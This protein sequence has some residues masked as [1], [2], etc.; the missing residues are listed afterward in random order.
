MRSDSVRVLYLKQRFD[1][2]PAPLR[3][4]GFASALRDHGVDLTVL[5]GFPYYPTPELY[6]GYAHRRHRVEEIDG[7]TVHRS[8][9]IVGHTPSPVRRLLSYVT[10][11]AMSTVNALVNNIRTDLVLTTLGPGVYA[12]FAL[13][14]ARRL[15]VPCVLEIQDLWP[16]SLTASGMWPKRIPTAPVE[17]AMRLAYRNATAITCLSPGCRDAVIARGGSPASTVSMLNWAPDIEIS[18]SDERR[19]TELLGRWAHTDFIGYAGSLGPLQGVD[20]M[21]DA[22]AQAGTR[23][24]VLGDGRDADALQAHVERTGTAVRFL[25][26]QP[27][28]V[29]RALLRQAAA[30]TV[31]L[32][33]SELDATAIPSKVAANVTVGVPMVV[34]ANGETKRLAERIDAGPLCAPGDTHALAHSFRAVLNASATE[35]SRWVR[36]ANEFASYSVNAKH[37]LSRYAGFLGAVARRKGISELIDTEGGLV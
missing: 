19:A 27:P 2:E 15:A 36:N 22:A 8:A 3:G 1:P 34:A 18:A 14:L 9:S 32:A 35:R 30:S 13:L 4:A 24:V 21:C 20:R 25:G 7:T 12:H 23:L 29:T 17:A 33:A 10:M 6:Q 16:E 37:G 31:Y 11:P 26:Q 28:G 5:T